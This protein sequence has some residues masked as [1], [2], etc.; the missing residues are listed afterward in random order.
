M[1]ELQK[2]REQML[3]FALQTIEYR[4]PPSYA[5][6]GTFGTHQ[7]GKGGATGVV[8]LV[9]GANRLDF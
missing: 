4:P 7:E 6:G 3:N 5:K 2:L 1:L 9:G 8:A